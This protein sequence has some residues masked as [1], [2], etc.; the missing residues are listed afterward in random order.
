MVRFSIEPKDRIFV[1]LY[2]FCI[3]LK[4]QADLLIKI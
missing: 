2:G 4:K 1:K 3:L